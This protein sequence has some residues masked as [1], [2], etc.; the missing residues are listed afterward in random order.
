M[1][2]LSKAFIEEVSTW[3]KH[4]HSHPELGFDEHHTAQFVAERLQSFGITVHTQV[5]NTGVIGILKK[6]HRQQSIGL[7]ADMDALPL[8]E[9]NTFEHRSC[10]A[11]KMHAC[12]HDGHTAMLLGAAKYLSEQGNFDGTVYFIFQPAEENLGGG[13]QMVDEGLFERFPMDEVYAIHNWPG[14]PLGTICA[15][16]DAMMASFDTFDI[17]LHG[18]GCHAAMPDQGRDP[19]I[20]AAALIQSLQTIVAREC[21]PLQPAVLSITQITSGSTYNI[22]PD[23]AQLKGTVRTFDQATRDLIKTRLEQYVQNI[24]QAHD[25]QGQLDYQDGYPS[26]INTPAC[27]Q[28]VRQI[29]RNLFGSDKVPD[30]VLPSM[31]SEDFSCLLQAKKGAYIWIGTDEPNRKNASLHNPHYDFNDHIIPIGIRLWIGLVEQILA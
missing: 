14:L 12:G 17:T 5:A 31:G 21:S 6:G 10:H 27:A 16:D 13:K 29:A 7:R 28:K 20:A 18:K 11:G 9:L 25:V 19:I 15:N 1:N 4:L 23:Q 30:Q 26:T 3:R 2:T 24:A 8:N 22:I